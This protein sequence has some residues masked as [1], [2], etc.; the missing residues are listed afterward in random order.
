MA[1]LGPTMTFEMVGKVLLVGLCGLT[2][3][4]R[5]EL[6]ST[7]ALIT[8][9]VDFLTFMSFYPSGLSLV[10]E[11][12]FNKNGR[13]QWD[14]KQIIKMLP[15]EDTQNP[16]VYRVRVI[17]MT[18]LVLVHTFCRW[19]VDHSVAGSARAASYISSEWLKLVVAN[20]EQFGILLV[21]LALAVKYLFYEDWEE[22]FRIRKTYLEELER[23]FDDASESDSVS[24]ENNPSERS[25]LRPH[26]HEMDRS[27]NSTDEGISLS[28]LSTRRMSATFERR[29]SATFEG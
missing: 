17:A 16:V 4:T 21:V 8:V 25:T 15:Q 1:Q 13:P 7:F 23:K 10:I 12:M 20:A 11:L 24:V 5:L 26:T 14:V 6:V 2:N 18:G 28:T 29:M 19:P 22:N 9:F 3:Y 27:S